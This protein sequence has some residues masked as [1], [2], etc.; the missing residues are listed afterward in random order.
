MM[1]EIMGKNA[2]VK[3]KTGNAVVMGRTIPRDATEVNLQ[4]YFACEDL[5]AII[6]ALTKYK[7]VEFTLITDD[8]KKAVGVKEL[9]KNAVITEP[10]NITE[11][12]ST[13]QNEKKAP[14]RAKKAE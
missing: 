8:G 3:A 1:E 14:R 9:P 2:I 7:D 5:D 4:K 12:E 6:N 10:D 11:T 13:E